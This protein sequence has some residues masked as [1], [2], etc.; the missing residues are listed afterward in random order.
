MSAEL[1]VLCGLAGSGTSTWR[2]EHLAATHV[3]V[4][5]DLMRSRSG[6]EARQQREIRAALGAGR[7]V[8]VDNTNLT[9]EVRAALLALA[10]EFGVP[11][12]AV[13]VHVPVEL[14]LERNA[15]REGPARVPD[16]IVRQM[17]A[18]WE[19][20]VVDEGFDSVEFVE[21]EP[22]VEVM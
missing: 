13:V 19:E 11:A 5:K 20:P 21:Q 1:V 12:R 4:S 17:A 10:R 6:K 18:L 15:Q 9:R 2:R 22:A 16:G 3:V 8:V 14:A 7:A